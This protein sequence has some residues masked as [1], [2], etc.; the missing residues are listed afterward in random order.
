M[1]AER[2]KG[3]AWLAELEGEAEKGKAQTARKRGTRPAGTGVE[4]TVTTAAGPAQAE[5]TGRGA[6]SSER[7]GERTRASRARAGRGTSWIAAAA[8]RGRRGWRGGGVL[9]QMAAGPIV[10]SPA[11]EKAREARE[12]RQ[13][14]ADAVAHG[15]GGDALRWLDEARALDPAGDAQAEIVGAEATGGGDG[16]TGDEGRVKGAGGGGSGAP[17]RGWGGDDR[18]QLLLQPGDNYS[19][20]Q[21]PGGF[22][23][24]SQERDGRRVEQFIGVVVVGSVVVV[25]V[26]VGVFKR[27]PERAWRASRPR[28][29]A[30]YGLRIPG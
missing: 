13:R 11:P 7:R 6:R 22:V 20:S 26:V 19:C 27:R 8:A 29:R 10:A 4:T 12:L 23:A 5:R 28:R 18:R 21:P 9:L 14:A 3:A 15:K 1:A 16:G 25:V 2:A 30:C 17:L 24:M